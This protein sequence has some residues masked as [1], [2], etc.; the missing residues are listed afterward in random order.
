V[1]VKSYRSFNFGD[2]ELWVDERKQKRIGLAAERY[3]MENQI[4]DVDCRFDVITV[5][6]AQQPPQIKHIE[7]AFWLDE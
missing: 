6:L 4:E 2:A 5:N 1:E 7:N 3:L